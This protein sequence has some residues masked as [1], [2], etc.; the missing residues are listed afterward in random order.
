MNTFLTKTKSFFIRFKLEIAVLA[1]VFFAFNLML[2]INGAFPYG[3]HTL[4]LSDSFAQTGLL[5]EHIFDFLAGKTGLF[6]NSKLGGGAEVFSMVLYLLCNPFFLLVL[7]F[8]KNNIFKS[9]NFVFFAQVIFVSIIAMWF[10]KKHFKNIS[11]L[12][13]VIISIAYT[14]SSYLI[15]NICMVTWLIFPAIILIIFDRFLEL[16]NSGKVV[17]F[18]LSIFWLVITSFVVGV[19]SNIL[20]LIIFVA[21]IFLNKEKEEQKDIF[22]RL[23]FA[24]IVAVLLSLCVLLP[25]L[26][27]ILKTN[28]AGS[29]IQTI[30][31]DKTS[32]TFMQKLAYVSIDLFWIIFAVVYFIKMNKKSKE[33]KFW[34]TAAVVALAPAIFDSSLSLLFGGYYSGFPGR[35]QFVSTAVLFVL[36]CKFFNENNI[37]EKQNNEEKSTRLFFG[38]YVFMIVLF[39]VAILFFA[40]FQLQKV[41]MSLK[42]PIGASGKIYRVVALIAVILVVLLLAALL[43]EKRKVLS[44][45]VFRFSI[46][47]TILFS[48]LSNVILFSV[49]SSSN[50]A[51]MVSIN[52]VLDNEDLDG[53]VK[54]K[55]KEL[56]SIS[57]NNKI[58]SQGTLNYFS[59]TIAAENSAI[60][61]LGYFEDT[62][63]VLA[64]NGTLIAD[65]LVG[66]KYL[67]TKT[68]QNRPYLK[69]LNKED[70]CYIY[71]NT[72]ATTGALMFDK[73]IEFDEDDIL[74]SFENL[75]EK[76]GIEDSLFM[77]ISVTVEEITTIDK[78]YAENVYRCSII[79]PCDGILYLKNMNL[80]EQFNE[81]A[82]NYISKKVDVDNIYSCEGFSEGQTDIG[83]ANS[84]EE[85]ISYLFNVEDINN[86]EFTFLNY[87]AAEKV[88][89]KLQERQAEFEYT[90]SG[91][92]ITGNASEDEKLVV[93]M[94]NIDG[95]TYSVNGEKVEASSILG[96][97]VMIS[98]INGKFELIAEYSYP[99]TTLW[100]VTI[101]AS[102]ILLVGVVIFYKFTKFRHIKTFAR[103]LFISVGAIML[104]V[105]VFFGIVLTFFKLLL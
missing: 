5:F 6:Y 25:A 78:L 65:S 54:I 75:A 11:K 52:K 56:A 14:F 88:C 66:L 101:I 35:I 63:C 61:N 32:T 44:K 22:A 100:I 45:R 103:G 74:K 80:H 41:A 26:V 92:K 72:L 24:Y 51:D 8:G 33:F 91:Y 69:L 18:S 10:I 93:F 104:S 82:K 84:G 40:G 70:K 99:N 43:G 79:A 67:I 29:I 64:E 89:Q 85:L 3:K 62:V 19:A 105:F 81:S 13:F 57:L 9:F 55:Q 36:T 102:L 71:E 96:G 77:D 37:L 87:D 30:F 15:V 16:E 60:S 50:M 90:K 97:M 95:M 98:A 1:I 46:L 39:F 21:H 58:F 53:K 12:L 4:L 2:I 7:P 31:M 86:V 76:M 42:D 17:G 49:A 28:R 59:S 68:E 73:E 27:A 23:L 94:A 20:L 38:L 48:T 47:F 34:L 83:Y